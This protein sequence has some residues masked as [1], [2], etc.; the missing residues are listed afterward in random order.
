MKSHFSKIEL[1]L[2]LLYREI[3]SGKESGN[4]K[5]EKKKE[6]EWNGMR[7]NPNQYT[8]DLHQVFMRPSLAQSEIR[9][10]SNLKLDRGN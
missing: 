6:T 3:G 4:W 9:A 5:L 8:F 2:A 7:G 1:K 10:K